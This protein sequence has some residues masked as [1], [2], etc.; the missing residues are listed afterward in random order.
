[1]ECHMRAMPTLSVDDGPEFHSDM[2]VSKLTEHNTRAIE[3]SVVNSTPLV[4]ET[5]PTPTGPNGARGLEPPDPNSG[6]RP[7]EVRRLAHEGLEAA[8]RQIEIGEKT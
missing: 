5:R 3:A 2:L 6:I 4:V 8:S 7:T 1:M